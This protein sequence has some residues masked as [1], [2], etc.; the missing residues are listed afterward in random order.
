LTVG[1]FTPQLML[2]TRIYDIISIRLCNARR[3]LNIK[4]QWTDSRTSVPPGCCRFIETGCRSRRGN[5]LNARTDVR[6]FEMRTEIDD[7]DSIPPSTE[8]TLAVSPYK[9]RVRVS[10][11][12]YSEESIREVMLRATFSYHDCCSGD[13]ASTARL[14][15]WY[16]M[17]TGG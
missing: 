5:V 11:V 2:P 12:H 4:Y 16:N 14:A 15:L 3:I 10:E 7:G 17:N 13:Y 9:P 1:D 8:G 6:P